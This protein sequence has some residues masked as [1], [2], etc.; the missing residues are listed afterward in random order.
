MKKQSAAENKSKGKERFSALV[1][2]IKTAMR[3]SPKAT[4][5]RS[6]ETNKTCTKRY[7]EGQTSQHPT[8]C[9]VA[10]VP[11]HVRPPNFR[12]T[13]APLDHM[14]NAFLEFVAI[15]SA[16]KDISLAT[17]KNIMQSF[18]LGSQWMLDLQLEESDATVYNNETS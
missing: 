5:N 7:H 1:R 4:K 10:A 14:V 2:V 11:V 15:T 9:R 8:T 16:T 18:Q 13:S 12:Q 3:G 17:C 6:T